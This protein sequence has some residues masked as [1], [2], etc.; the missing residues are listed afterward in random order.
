MSS[1]ELCLLK[2]RLSLSSRSESL[3]YKT[4]ID[5]TAPAPALAPAPVPAPESLLVLVFGL[6]LPPDFPHELVVGAPQDVDLHLEPE[7]TAPDRQPSAAPA[8]ILPLD[9]HVHGVDVHSRLL[10]LRHQL[11]LQHL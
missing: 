11:S 4:S 7:D 3:G 5:S 8:G 2:A 1:S 10:P 6:Q 9:P